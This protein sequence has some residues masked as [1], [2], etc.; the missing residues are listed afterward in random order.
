MRCPAKLYKFEKGG[1]DFLIDGFDDVDD[2]EYLTITSNGNKLYY[3]LES[4]SLKNHLFEYDVETGSKKEEMK[5][6]DIDFS[7]GIKVI[8]GY[9][10]YYSSNN[11]N[12]IFSKI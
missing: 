8:N 11:N 1:N 4:G 2:A 7:F 12:V 10:V 6:D 3:V 9:V 5:L